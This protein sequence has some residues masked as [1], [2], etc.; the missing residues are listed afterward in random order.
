[1]ILKKGVIFLFVVLLLTISVTLVSA[2]RLPVVNSDNS[3]WGT[4]L[5]NYL[6]NVA[7]Q[8]GTELN[9]TMVNGTNI[10]SSAINS[11]HIEDDSLGDDDLSDLMNL[12]LGHKITFS[13][14]EIIDNI[15]NGWIRITGSLNV[16]D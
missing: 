7:G 13:L 4:I 16:T 14:G 3:T 9:N 6:I 12:T 15:I 11:T 5:N 1:M 2:E 8:N 10:Y